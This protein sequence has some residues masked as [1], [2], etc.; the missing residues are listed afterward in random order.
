[1]IKIKAYNVLATNHFSDRRLGDSRVK[2][3]LGLGLAWLRL[4][5]EL[6]GSGSG[7]KICHTDIS[8]PYN[9]IG[10]QQLKSQKLFLSAFRSKFKDQLHLSAGG[11]KGYWYIKRHTA[12]NAIVTVLVAFI[13]RRTTGVHQNLQCQ[14]CIACKN[15][16]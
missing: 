2:L 1:M 5:L 16:Q 8:F 7:I 12:N 10:D 11:K 6:A 15:K 14:F 9:E 13:H 4:V 3:W